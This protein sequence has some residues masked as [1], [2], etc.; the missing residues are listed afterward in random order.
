MKEPFGLEMSWTFREF[1][2]YC[3][4]GSSYHTK[5]DRMDIIS[6]IM[7]GQKTRKP[8]ESLC[9][10]Y[11]PNSPYLKSVTINDKEYLAVSCSKCRNIRLINL[12]HNN[13]VINAYSGDVGPMCHGKPGTLY[14][15]SITTLSLLNCTRTEFTLL[16][17]VNTPVSVVVE[18]IE[19]IIDSDRIAVIGRSAFNE[20]TICVLS[21]SGE[22]IWSK[23]Y[24][25]LRAAAYLP[26]ENVLLLCHEGDVSFLVMSCQVK[27]E[28]I[29]CATGGVLQNLALETDIRFPYTC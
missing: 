5:S 10:H 3:Q 8:I 23:K 18:S 2:T 1:P 29:S 19:Y 21:A 4:Q 16:Q 14:T 7:D 13:R 20:S 26:M 28:V 22:V 9:S 15:C 11:K 24:P 27:I 12:Q 6:T 25:E 17:K